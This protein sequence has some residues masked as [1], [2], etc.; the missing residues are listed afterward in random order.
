MNPENNQFLSFKILGCILIF[1]ICSTSNAKDWTKSFEAGKDDINGQ[2]MG[3]SEVLH[4]VGHDGSLYA[5]VGYWRDERNIWYGGTDF[6][7]GW[8]QVLRLDSPDGEWEVD[9]DMGAQHLRP[10]II[11]EITFTTDSCGAALNEPVTL[12]I[13]GA[14]T[15]SLTCVTANAFTRNDETGKWVKA[16]I[17]TGPTPGGENY[18][19]R[20]FHVHRDSVTG[21]D[22]IF[23]TIGSKGIF[24]GV[25]DLGAPSKIKWDSAPEMG[26]FKVRPLGIAAANGS[27]LFSSGENI[28]KRTDGE[29]PTYTLVHD[30]SDLNS[31]IK[32]A[33][34]GI[35]GLTTIPNPNGS[36]D[37]LMF[38]W[39]PNGKSQ[40]VIYRLEPDEKGGYTRHHE[41]QLSDLMRDYINVRSIN[42]LLGAY[43]EFLAVTN[44][45][46]GKTEHFVGFE[47]T[48]KGGTFPSW[49]NG[50]YRGAMFAVRDENQK[51]RLEEVNG[52]ITA[53]DPALVSVRCYIHSP[54]KDENA[55]YF[56]GHDP[57]GVTSTNM[58]W[59][60]KMT[61]ANT[62]NKVDK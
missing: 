32:S 57:N 38:M 45:I 26:P 4:L 44:P 5:A 53:T 2:Y 3:G 33:V 22:R 6:A 61:L 47:C 55:I 11:K 12:L 13:A 52:K 9:L 27:L 25:Y 40:G 43:N 7:T 10:E 46:T 14:Y 50:Y 29:K 1:L 49:K 58:A 34:G 35:R 56:G 36:G 8:G 31:T 59:I 51:Y 16:K 19:V 20:D 18:S 54:F 15:P 17:I 28:Y 42:Y 37:A 60:Y 24:S 21:I 48:T 30:L 62:A 41:I 23:V 39:S